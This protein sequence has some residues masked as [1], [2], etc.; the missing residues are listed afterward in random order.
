MIMS[1]SPNAPLAARFRA[2]HGKDRLLVLP[3]AWDVASAR[4]IE[5]SGA[6]AIATTSAAL[7]WSLGYMDGEDLPLDAL[8][9]SVATITRRASVPVTVDFVLG[10]SQDPE[11]VAA[12]VLRLV[13]AG[14][15]GVNL[16]DGDTPPE[17]LAQKIRAVRKAVAE[18]GVDVFINARID[19]YLRGLVPPAEAV[20][21]T[22]RRAHLYTEAGCDGLFA[23][24]VT[25]AD[26]IQAIVRGTT[27]PLNVMLVPGIASIADLRSWG[28]RRLSAGPGL[29]E[30][31][32]GAAKRACVELL[33]QGSYAGVFAA[34]MT[35]PEMNGLFQ[36][37]T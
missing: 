3:N 25:N 15:V 4:L 19:V 27:L 21:E 24:M 13:D 2:L 17:L 12:A 28:V 29:A 26:D 5:A 14:A 8:V 36:G 30:V 16:E 6:E 20:A 32:Y 11:L 7:A 33:G 23:A 35:Y 31:A 1:T 9:T 10:Y 18:R 34:G 22:I 37:K